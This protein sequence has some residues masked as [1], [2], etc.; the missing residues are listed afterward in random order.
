MTGMVQAAD[1]H[2]ARLACRVVLANPPTETNLDL[3]KSSGLEIVR[4][5][6]Q[7]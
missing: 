7:G 5:K 1:A 2:R 4:L 3:I 6:V